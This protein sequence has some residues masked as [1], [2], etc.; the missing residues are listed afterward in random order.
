MGQFKDS[1]MEGYGEFYWPD[2]KKY[3]GFYKQDKK[4]GLGLFAWPDNN[5][6]Y[7]GC[8]VNG[9]QEGV[10]M[11]KHNYLTKYGF[12]ENGNRQTWIK[13]AWALNKYLKNDTYLEF[14][15]KDPEDMIN[16]FMK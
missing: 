14:F 8:W 16:Y 13:G 15:Q 10:G 1:M 11:M 9:K 4:E 6:I 2:G 3:I 7:V 12:W 5:K